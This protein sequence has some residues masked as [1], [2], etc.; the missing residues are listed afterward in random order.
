MKNV[1]LLSIVLSLYFLCSLALIHLQQDNTQ[2]NVSFF[3]HYILHFTV[4]SC[5]FFLQ[6]R[7]YICIFYFLPPSLASNIFF[8]KKIIAI[9]K[10]IQ[11]NKK[12]QYV[13][14]FQV[15]GFVYF[16]FFLSSLTP[17][18]LSPPP[19]VA[20]SHG[21]LGAGSWAGIIWLWLWGRGRCWGGGGVGK[22]DNWGGSELAVRRFVGGEI[23]F[24]NC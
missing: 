8:L 17:L 24:R 21:E 22:A 16:L 7:S 3:T 14:K 5:H 2:C 11:K 9:K 19:P 1:A 6:A 15:P 18:P 4:F 20:A 23:I 12:K 13:F 10:K